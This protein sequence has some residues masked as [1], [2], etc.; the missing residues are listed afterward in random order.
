MI[1]KSKQSWEIGS[2]VKVGF[3]QLTVKAAIA[4]PG[5]HKPDQY[6]LTDATGTRCYSFTPHYGL[7]R[8]S[9]DDAREL[10]QYAQRMA[11]DIASEA[12]RVAQAN[13]KA[14]AELD[15]L[16]DVALVSH[17]HELARAECERT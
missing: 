8:I 2:T 4:T 1:T 15:A 12:T 3:L 6:L 16:F 10:L 14:R 13:A 9:A 7:G 11:Q 5:D 17:R